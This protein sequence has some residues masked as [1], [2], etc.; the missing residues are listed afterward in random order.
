[1]INFIRWQK[2]TLG[3]SAI[4]VALA[5]IAFAVWRV[6]PGIDFTGGALLQ[7]R[8][9]GERPAAATIEKAILAQGIPEAR[10]QPSGDSEAFLRLSPLTNEAKDALL[11]SL[12][13][14]Y[15]GVEEQSFSSVG[16][17]MGGELQRKAIMAVAAVLL[18]IILYIT[19]AFRRVSAGP[20]PAWFYGLG[21][22]IA[23]MHDIL[24]PLGFYAVL[25][26]V[27]GVEV[28]TLFVTALLT[29]LGFSV[30]DT[31]V[32][33]DRVR[34]NLRKYSGESF[35]SI[36]NIS[37]NETL[38][39]SINTSLTAL[40][41]LIALFLFGGESIHYFVLVLALGIAV[42]TY[43]SIFVAGPLLVLWARHKGRA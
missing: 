32:V 16:P 2:L 20:V 25:G 41:V 18:G 17:T 22:I 38:I 5:L 39:R 14:A 7:I 1:M 12:S 35:S 28:D 13:G 34:E 19:W 43:S 27:A 37:L 15:G 10:V 9:S 33:Y 42:G 6:V 21:A 23:L 29:I 3:L 40:L 8:F 26:K 30:H 24:I 4:A 36:V 11:A 31:I